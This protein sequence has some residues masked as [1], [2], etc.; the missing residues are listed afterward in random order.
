MTAR[1]WQTFR[2]VTVPLALPA[3]SSGLVLSLGA[4][5]GRVRRDDDACGHFIGRTQT[6]PLAVMGAMESDLYA[7]PALSVVLGSPPVRRAADAV[8]GDRRGGE[9]WSCDWWGMVRQYVS[10]SVLST[11]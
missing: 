9:G 7:A 3:L 10:A 11:H 6:M 4:G 8:P 5:G 1:P 2:L